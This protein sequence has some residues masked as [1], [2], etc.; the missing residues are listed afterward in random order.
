MGI[1]FALFILIVLAVGLISR[2][3]ERRD[4]VREE[5]HDESGA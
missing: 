2:R 4:W 5:R 1:F 3:R